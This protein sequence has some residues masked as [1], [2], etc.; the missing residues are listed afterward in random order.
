MDIRIDIDSQVPGSEQNL[1]SVTDIEHNAFSD[2]PVMLSA[3][4]TRGREVPGSKLAW[5]NWIL[6]YQPVVGSIVWA[7]RRLK[8]PRSRKMSARD[9]AS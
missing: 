3:R 1:P 6:P 2:S 7:F 9:Y 4:M 8:K 5:A